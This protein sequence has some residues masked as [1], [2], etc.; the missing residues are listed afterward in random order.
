[1]VVGEITEE[2]DLIIIGG[3]PGGYTAAIRAA[4]L[5]L[6]VTLVEQADL[7]GIC[8]N[9]G[10]IPSKVWT[11]AAKKK[12]EIPQMQKMGL[13]VSTGEIDLDT[14][15]DYKSQITEQLRKGV[16]A[17]CQA[18]KIEVIQGK[19]T[20]TGGDRIGVE[21]GHQFDTYLFDKAIIATG[22]TAVFPEHFPKQGERIF[23]S[24]DIFNF[25]EIPEHLIVY[26]RDLIA[27]EMATTY[28]SFGS[29]VT[30][31][32]DD[33]INLD[34]A[35]EKELKRSL[36]KKKIRLIKKDSLKSIEETDEGVIVSLTDDKGKEQTIEGSHLY[37]SGDRQPN[38]EPLGID[39]FGIG[40]TSD[41]HIIVNNT[42][43]SS[44]PSIYAIG[45][46]TEGPSLAIKAIKQGK[47]AAEA[48][49][50]KNPEVDLTFLPTIMHTTPPI[51]SVGLTE[52]EAEEHDL[53]IHVGQ[54]NLNANGY[55]KLT[56]QTDGMIKVISDANTEIILGIHMIGEGAI[57]LSSTFVQLLEMAA[58]VEDVT[59]PLYAHPSTNEGLLEAV[60]ALTGQSIHLPP[61]KQQT[62]IVERS[63]T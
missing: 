46:V 45:D 61:T 42:M 52:Q 17:L 55:A 3:G 8:L 21:Y 63:L 25:K 49:A 40:Q 6:E 57:E 11:H 10:C 18:N 2:R 62:K 51:A 7:G 58:K 22:S 60:D 35:I 36:K 23:L 5:G 4:Q 47:V 24:H 50:G 39:R 41:G 12:S 15:I 48:I 26:G 31:I 43:Q 56:G 30:L 34:Q 13:D 1:M 9:Q 14:L 27:F 54:F 38:L 16:E 32:Q 29:K 33:D 19:A 37:T 44:I 20:F 28:Q 53:D 59:F